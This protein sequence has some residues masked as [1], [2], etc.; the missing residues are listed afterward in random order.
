[1]VILVLITLIL[2]SQVNGNFVMTYSPGR[3]M[4]V[5]WHERLKPNKQ[6]VSIQ[7]GPTSRL[8]SSYDP[9]H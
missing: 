8:R 3:Y 2:R 7:P 5:V 1:M 4:L 6:A 9:Q